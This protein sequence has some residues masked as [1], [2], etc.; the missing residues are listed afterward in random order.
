MKDFFGMKT[1]ILFIIL[2]LLSFIIRFVNFERLQYGNDANVPYLVAHHIIKYHEFPLAI[3]NSMFYELKS[4]PTYFYLITL[5]VIIND[6]PLFLNLANLFL[7]L[8]TLC[9]IYLFA[10]K[11]FGPITALFA[12]ALFSFSTINLNQSLFIWGPFVMQ[13]FVNLSYLL[14]LLAFIKRSFNLIL[15]GITF[16]IFA[17][18]LHN[19]AFSLFPIYLLLCV[20]ILKKLK[21]KVHNYYLLFLTVIFSFTLLFLP[22]L[23]YWYNNSLKISEILNRGVDI[24]SHDFL[25][26][27]NYTSAIFIDNFFF[28]SNKNLFSSNMLILVVTIFAI[29]FYFLIKRDSVVRKNYSFIILTAI[30]CQFLFVNLLKLNDPSLSGPSVWG[31][32]RYFTPVLGLFVIIIAHI[33]NSVFTGNIV[34]RITKVIL[35]ILLLNTFSQGIWGLFQHTRANFLNP[36]HYG[37]PA[38][39]SMERE[40]LA[41]Q[42]KENASNLNFF[43][44]RTYGHEDTNSY[45]WVI[46][47]RD[48][49]SKFTK[50]SD[51]TWNSYVTIND[52]KYIFL[53]CY[54]LGNETCQDEFTRQNQNYQILSKVYSQ[55]PFSIYLTKKDH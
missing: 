5:F 33:I 37:H 11:A 49:D 2:L 54:K 21:A 34:I 20:Y 36:Q 48:L 1:K 51:T 14:L 26:N 3:F 45:F 30:L 38:A 41:L 7:Q 42:K 12:S 35:I 52:D 23:I 31:I 32:L 25:Q 44:L 16:F 8:F 55:H 15:V 46:L 6:H 47:E 50:T 28:I 53:I 4:S 27:L 29:L 39:E 10:Q 9:V 22:V 40:I 17:G 24:T 13:S 18:A 43:Q 19:S